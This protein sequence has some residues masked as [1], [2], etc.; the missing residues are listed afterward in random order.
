[1]I[2]QTINPCEDTIG[3]IADRAWE[4][5]TQRAYVRVYVRQLVFPIDSTIR[6]LSSLP[7][8]FFEL[9]VSQEASNDSPI[10]YFLSFFHN[11]YDLTFKEEIIRV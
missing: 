1:M 7:H 3:R 4:R 5:K 6:R 11:K 9:H 10:R 2:Y 8:P